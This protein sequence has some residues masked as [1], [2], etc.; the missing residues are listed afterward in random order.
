MLAKYISWYR[1]SDLVIIHFIIYCFDMLFKIIGECE[2]KLPESKYAH[3]EAD[4]VKKMTD[5]VAE[6]WKYMTDAQIKLK[7]LKQNEVSPLKA[8]KIITI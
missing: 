2:A 5:A 8:R 4:D 7:D 3:L 1:S 6:G